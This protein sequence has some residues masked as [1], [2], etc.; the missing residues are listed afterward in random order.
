MVRMRNY[1]NSR[2]VGLYKVLTIIFIMLCLVGCR[3]SCN[4]NF[5][6][7]KGEN[8]NDRYQIIKEQDYAMFIGS[9]DANLEVS[10]FTG[11]TNNLFVKNRGVEFKMNDLCFLFKD[12]GD[13]LYSNDLKNVNFCCVNFKE[14]LHENRGLF[15]RINYTIDSLGLLSN[16]SKEYNFMTVRN[17]YQVFFIEAKIN[18]SVNLSP[19]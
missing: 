4:Y 10:I 13:T 5:Y 1:A 12:T 7:D 9:T 18:L 11:N 2:N 14:K 6:I 17:Q 15:V 19:K 8:S 3:Y 16:Y